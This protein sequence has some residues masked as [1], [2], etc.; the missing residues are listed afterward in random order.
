MICEI[1]IE[2]SFWFFADYLQGKTNCIADALSRLQINKFKRLAHEQHL[3][4]D[5]A[6]MLFQRIPFDF[7]SGVTN[8]T[9][10]QIT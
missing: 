9:S 7:G 5:P 1:A 2:N 8:T 10:E 3:L 6:P 4:F